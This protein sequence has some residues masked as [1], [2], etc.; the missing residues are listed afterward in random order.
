LPGTEVLE[1][2]FSGGAGNDA[3]SPATKNVNENAYSQCITTKL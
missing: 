3:K 2:C 1:L